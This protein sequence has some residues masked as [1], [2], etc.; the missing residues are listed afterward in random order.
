[1]AVSQG[2]LE[3]ALVPPALHL[4]PGEAS[5]YP[6]PFGSL[7]SDPLANKKKQVKPRKV[8]RKKKKSVKKKKKKS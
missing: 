7:V 1:M 5:L 2:A 6:E 8:S 4:A 3:K